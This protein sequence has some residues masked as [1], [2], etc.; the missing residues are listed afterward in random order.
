MGMVHDI[1]MRYVS[2]GDE[3]VGHCLSLLQLLKVEFGLSSP[4]FV[5]SWVEW[6][7]K[8]K[9]GQF[10]VSEIGTFGWMTRMCFSSIV[11]HR[12][13]CLSLQSNHFI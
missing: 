13:F 9:I 12:Q 11:K 10:L 8:M 3:F 6:V 7:E 4:F 2:S 5:P 1:Y